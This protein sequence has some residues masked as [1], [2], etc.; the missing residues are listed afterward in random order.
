MSEATLDPPAAE[1]KKKTAT[2]YMVLKSE[3]K[4]GPWEEVGPFV[5]VGQP[6]AKL[7]AAES[8]GEGSD[9]LYFI[10]IPDSS[11][12]PQKPSV[13]VTTKITFSD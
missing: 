4:K 11:Y 1:E 8:V 12:K 10:A 3:S 6:A 9:N 5:T 7:A 13:K 2:R